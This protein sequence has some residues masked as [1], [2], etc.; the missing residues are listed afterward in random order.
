MDL[1]IQELK[2]EYID[3]LIHYWLASDAEYMTSMGVDM[4]KMPTREEW[5]QFLSRQLN[6]N[7]TE[8]ESYALIWLLNG[9]P[10]G[11]SNISKIKFGDHA[12][13]HL[14]LWNSERRQKGI[15]MKLLKL[16]IPHYFNNMQLQTLYCEPYAL[17]PAPNKLLNKIGFKFLKEYT[18]IP[19]W[20]NFEQPVNV[21]ELTKENFLRLKE[22]WL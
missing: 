15:G 11:H 3:D 18:G 17:N 8:K 9:N 1:S 5:V 22:K 19:G 2:Q 10:I 14:H 4:T 7:Y 12:F 6:Q 16:S 13:M 20:L 21:W